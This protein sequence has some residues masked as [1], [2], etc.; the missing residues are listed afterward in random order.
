LSMSRIDDS[1]TTIR[2]CVCVC[3]CRVEYIHMEYVI[4]YVHAYLIMSCA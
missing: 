1:I 4:G 3:V 2:V